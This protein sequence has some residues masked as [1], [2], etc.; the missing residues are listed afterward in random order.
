VVVLAIEFAEKVFDWQSG[1]VA[2]EQLL[3]IGHTHRVWKRATERRQS[4]ENMLQI[5]Y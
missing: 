3:L 4:I 1:D 2:Q 5:R